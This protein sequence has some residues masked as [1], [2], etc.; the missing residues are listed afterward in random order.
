MCVRFFSVRKFLPKLLTHYDEIIFKV[1]EREKNT[2]TL[3]VSEDSPET[4]LTAL[5]N[6]LSICHHFTV[7]FYPLKLDSRLCGHTHT[8]TRTHNSYLRM[9]S[10]FCTSYDFSHFQCGTIARFQSFTRIQVLLNSIKL[11]DVRIALYSISSFDG[12]DTAK[13]YVTKHST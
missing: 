6:S 3:I 10:T 13:I 11:F 7:I 2:H 9:Y 8:L 12:Q 1:L 5:K 4:S